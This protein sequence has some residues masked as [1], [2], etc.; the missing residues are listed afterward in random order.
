MKSIAMML[1]AGLA[2]FSSYVL[3]DDIF[4]AAEGT[5]MGRFVGELPGQK[6]MENKFQAISFEHEVKSPRDIASGQPSGR[7]QHQ[8]IKLTKRVGASSP[9]FFAAIATNEVLRAVT[10]DFLGTDAK[11]QRFIAYQ[12]LLTTASVSNIRQYWRPLPIPTPALPTAGDHLEE[13]SLTYQRITVKYP[14]LNGSAMD[15]WLAPQM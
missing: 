13:I 3:A 2:L 4:V 15:D 11:G 7:R 5:R 9:Q 10:I 6:G 1:A 14:P 12:I 8:P